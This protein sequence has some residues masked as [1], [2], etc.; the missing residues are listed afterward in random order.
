VKPASLFL[1]GLLAIASL[2][3]VARPS[4]LAHRQLLLPGDAG[5]I[6]E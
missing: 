5:A 2:A 3:A 1:C 4:V 6:V